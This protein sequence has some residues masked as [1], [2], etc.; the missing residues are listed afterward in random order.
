MC[1][2]S[3]TSNHGRGESFGEDKTK[4]GG[5][6]FDV[7]GAG[8]RDGLYTCES[9]SHSALPNTIQRDASLRQHS[10]S[11]IGA[12]ILSA[13]EGD[14]CV[15]ENSALRSKAIEEGYG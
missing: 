11:R 15:L 5:R 12:T 9:V 10:G 4:S 8:V 6:D 14:S 1:E 13:G 3:D 7:N 2:A